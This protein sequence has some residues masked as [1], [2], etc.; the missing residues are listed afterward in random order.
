MQTFNDQ[1]ERNMQNRDHDKLLQLIYRLS[2]GRTEEI[3][4]KKG[5]GKSLG[6]SQQQTDI[7]LERLSNQ[8]MIKPIIFNSLCITHLGVHEAEKNHSSATELSKRS[9]GSSSLP[10]SSN[11]KMSELL[12]TSRKILFLA[13]NPSNTTRLRLGKEAQEIEESLRLSVKRDQFALIQKHAVRLKDVYRALLNERPNIVHFSGHGD[14]DGLALEDDAGRTHLIEGETLSNLFGQFASIECVLLNACYSHAQAE[15]IAQHVPYVIGMKREI[16]D[17]IAINF[18]ARFYDA[19]GNGQPVQKS[20]KLAIAATELTPITVSRDIL[21][22]PDSV[23]QLKPEKNTPIL[24]V[25]NLDKTVKKVLAPPPATY[26][27]EPQ[28][29]DNRRS[30]SRKIPLPLLVSFLLLSSLTGGAIALLKNSPPK[31]NQQ[32]PEGNLI[33]PDEVTTHGDPPLVDNQP[34]SSEPP[35][36]NPIPPA[37]ELPAPE[38]PPPPEAP[39]T[40]ATVIEGPWS[41]EIVDER[42]QLTVNKVARLES[43][44]WQIH[45]RAD[46]FTDQDLR[47]DPFFNEFYVRDNVGKT[48]KQNVSI[49]LHNNPSNG[50]W[51]GIVPA[52]SYAR[53]YIILPIDPEATSISVNFGNSDQEPQLSGS[54]PSV[55]SGQNPFEGLSGS[56]ISVE[57]IPIK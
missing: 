26:P 39:A 48:Y 7:A 9:R 47:L 40:E 50:E 18:A 55:G 29:A 17:G 57:D 44:L 2:G 6:L 30:K 14:Q 53:G 42:L 21:T 36:S 11:Y 35:E 13:A 23:L 41:S 27:K 28:Q 10:E 24:V 16:D 52:D 46:N 32:P 43:G 31:D 51:I 4:A 33:T 12:I 56:K 20:Y 15:G 22:H 37:P 45:L 25:G 3:I 5:L 8:G 19:L 1:S 49:S 38:V 54:F 34:P